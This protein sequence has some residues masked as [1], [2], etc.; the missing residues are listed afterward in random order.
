MESKNTLRITTFLAVLL[1]VIGI[2][3]AR[4]YSVQVTKA[5]TVSTG[6]DTYTFYTQVSAARGNIYDR[7][8]VVL[9]S[10]RSSYNLTINDYI[11][12]SQENTNENLLK[13]VNQCIDLGLEYT[14]HLPISHTAPYTSTISDLSSTW[15]SYFQTYMA[16]RDWDVDMTA[17]NL[18]KLLRETYSIDESWSD[19]DARKVVGIR[20]ELELRHHIYA[21][22]TYVLC[23]D[24]SSDTLASIIEL[25]I[26]GVNV[27]TTTVREYNTTYAAHILG[28]VGKMTEE[29]YKTYG[30]L[31]YSMDAY[32]GKE[33]FEYAFEE[34]LHGVDGQKC[35]VI[36]TGGD[37]VEEYYITEPEAGDNVELTLD[38][39]IQKVAEDSLAAHIENIRENGVSAT[40]ENDGNGKDAEG[41]AVVVIECDTGDV[42]ACASYPTYNL[43]TYSEDFEALLADDY[44]PLYNR[45]LQAIYNPGS[46][47]KMVTG[48][49]A[50]DVLEYSPLTSIEDKGIFTYYE[51]EGFTPQCMI[52]KNSGVT[53]GPMDLRN[54]LS[55]SCNYYFYE[56]ANQIYYKFNGSYEPIDEIAKAMGLGESTGVE[57]SESTGYRANA[58]T[59]AMLYGVDESGFY[60]GD[61]LAA[62]IG[63]SENKFTVL[64][65]A[66]YAATLAN[67]GTRYRTTFLQRVVSADY[68]TLVKENEPEVVND[69]DISNEAMSAVIDG[70]KLCATEGTAKKTFADYGIAVC[71]KTGT[72]EHESGGSSHASFICFAPAD[73]PEIAIAV[74]VEKGGSGSSLGTIAKDILDAYFTD[75]SS[76]EVSY[77]E[78]IPN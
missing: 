38:I 49:A 21:L 10:N 56:V 44:A 55:V 69:L 67:E 33:G 11:I 36:S 15:Q 5:E 51:D 63:Q 74:Y 46:T 57:L 43:S 58:E 39:G 48:I 22:S 64:Q 20:Y 23:S 40:S 6:S 41:G 70:M 19:E 32:V 1:V 77:T 37:I 7:N 30:E 76:K 61:A 12:Y 18:L 65:M 28:S 60:G 50:I 29:E 2:F 24:V 8:G 25:G 72:A 31:G 35:T 45:A 34:Y 47:Y 73:N 26:P 17:T 9:V 66:T 13:L 54:A 71:A 14:D 59:K 27:E 53:H 75:D 78:G 62:A 68:R 42:L 3:V 16:E 4:L 52:Y